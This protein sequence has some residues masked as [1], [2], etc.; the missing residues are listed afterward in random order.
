MRP[1]SCLGAAGFAVLAAVVPAAGVSRAEGGGRTAEKRMAVQLP[2]DLPPLGEEAAPKIPDVVASTL[3]NGVVVQAVRRRG[4]PLVTVAL[5]VRGGRSLDPLDRPGLASLLAAALKEGTSSR[6]AAQVADALQSAGAELETFAD[7]DSLVVSAS[8]LS[9]GTPILVDVLADVL[10]RA[11]FPEGGV[12]RVKALAREELETN[13]S[14]PGFVASR[15]LRAALF[16]AHPY[17]GMSPDAATID[18]TTPA[19]LHRERARRVRPER[20]LV[21]GVGDL[22]AGAFERLATA[23]FADLARP[24]EDLPEVPAAAPL[25]APAVALLER[26]GSVQ[27]QLAIGFCGMTRT[28]PLRAPFAVANA[29]LGGTFS[30]RL[31]TNLREE[32]GYTYGAGSSS[33][34]LSAGGFVAVSTAVRNEV[35]GAALNEVLYEVRR[36]VTTDPS[37][38]ELARAKASLRGDWS[39]MLE[40]NGGLADT[41]RNL[42]LGGQPVSEIAARPAAWAAVTAADAR[43]AARDLLGDPAWALV[44]V[45]DGDVLRR[46]LR[47]FLPPSAK[48]TR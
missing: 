35:T 47:P 48:E 23:A 8:G 21:L 15:A 33:R 17:A 36:L 38:E 22:D 40:T 27:T 6:S 46:E 14:D 12:A 9:S 29:I 39:L 43:R 37:D 7:E 42:W 45:G 44:G 1:R 41:L 16:G 25:R 5:V 19:L 3:P 13:E 34:A 4:L 32:K 28:S 31:M 10:R 20:L 2:K 24:A 11:A 30:A 18:A 26:P